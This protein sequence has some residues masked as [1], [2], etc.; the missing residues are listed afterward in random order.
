MSLDC[1]NRT[2]EEKT[3]VLPE[4]IQFGYHKECSHQVTISEDDLKAEKRDPTIDY[5]HGLVYGSKILQGTV[6]FEVKIVSYC[7]YW[8][9]SDDEDSISLKLGVMRCKSGTDLDSGNYPIPR[10]SL[11]GPNHC[12]W[13]SNRI[14]NR[15]KGYLQTPYGKE[16][17]DNLREGDCVGLRLTSDGVLVFFVNGQSQGVAAENVYEKGYDVY[18]VVDHFANCKSTAITRAGRLEIQHTR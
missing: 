4:T 7:A 17:L 16:N 11:D 18:P 13:S 9:L 8:I 14:H 5:A 2:I 1:S 10:C 3:F 12:V 6:E 15:I